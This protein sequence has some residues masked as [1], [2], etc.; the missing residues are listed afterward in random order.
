MPKLN[1]PS[2]QSERIYSYKYNE[3]NTQA[4]LDMCFSMV[5]TKSVFTIMSSS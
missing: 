4:N 2:V 3:K 1:E 5:L